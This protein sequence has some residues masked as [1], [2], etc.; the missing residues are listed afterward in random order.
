MARS[1]KLD[2]KRD[3]NGDVVMTDIQRPA[4]SDDIH[5]E[6][7]SSKQVQTGLI[8]RSSK[9]RSDQGETGNRE[10]ST[11]DDFKKIKKTGSIGRSSRLRSDEG[12][13]GNRER[14]PKKTGSTGSSSKLRWDEGETENVNLGV[15]IREQSPNDG[16]KKTGTTGSSSKLRSFEG[17]TE[18]V[19]LGVVIREQSPND[20]LI[21]KTGTT[22]SSLKLRSF[23]GETGNR[24]LA[25]VI[26][27]RSPKDRCKKMKRR[28][29]RGKEEEVITGTIGVKREY[30]G[31]VVM[32]DIQRPEDLSKKYTQVGS[33]ENTNLGV[34]I[35]ERTPNNGI[36]KIKKTA[37]LDEADQ[38]GNR[39][40]GVVIRERKD[41]GKELVIIDSD[42]ECPD[43][44]E[45]KNKKCARDERSTGRGYVVSNRPTT[46]KSPSPAMDAKKVEVTY[47]TGSDGKEYLIVNCCPC[48]VTWR[49]KGTGL[50]F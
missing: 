7:F 38:T 44:F 46:P 10:R 36:K 11:K 42:Y 8:G 41:K 2:V 39:D 49:V 27:E 26:R 31:D 15:V 17:E 1:K 23:E 50:S 35:R 34:V 47:Y 21:K 13:T 20:G 18:N 37:N 14:S 32:T 9:L 43:K 22:E 33:S 12:E 28:G 19:N 25:V 5:D 45:A 3:H 29:D 40:P 6:D 24:D 30:N 4:D 48:D 16:L